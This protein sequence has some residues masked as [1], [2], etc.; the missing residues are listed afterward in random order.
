M[1]NIN[2]NNLTESIESDHMNIAKKDYSQRIAVV[3]MASVLAFA[4]LTGI[5]SHFA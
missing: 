4:F 3:F 5:V 2:P 1:I